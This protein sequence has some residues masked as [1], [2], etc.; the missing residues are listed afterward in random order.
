MFSDRVFVDFDTKSVI[1]IHPYWNTDVMKNRFN[2]SEDS[3]T[4]DN[5]HDGIVYGA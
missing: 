4:P 5:I 2:D 1:D 3:D